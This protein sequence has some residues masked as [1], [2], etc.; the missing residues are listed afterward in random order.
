MKKV[1]SILLCM[2]AIFAVQAQVI[3]KGDKFWNGTVLYTVTE[4][5]LGKIVYMQGVDASGNDYELT[6]EKVGKKAGNY[7]LIP[8][9]Q[10]DDS[11]FRCQWNSRVTYIRKNGMYFL[12]V[13]NADVN[14]IVETL[15]L[16]PDNITDCQA[17]MEEAK[18]RSVASLASSYLL[19]QELTAFLNTADMKEYV[20]KFARKKKRTII[21]DTNMQLMKSELQERESCR[22]DNG[23]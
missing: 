7:K 2:C 23:F 1:L 16:T 3:K 8:S 20:K 18:Q 6:L 17:Q 12:A 4:I 10:A 22:D 13:H 21:E 9:C 19:N 11:P 14:L 15:V 5:R